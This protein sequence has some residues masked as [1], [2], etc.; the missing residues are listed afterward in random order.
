MF[1]EY[2][3]TYFI[4]HVIQVVARIRGLTWIAGSPIPLLF[5]VLFQRGALWLHLHVT[6]P[7]EGCR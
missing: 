5:R 6:S 3:K 2:N 1:N 7:K 4:N